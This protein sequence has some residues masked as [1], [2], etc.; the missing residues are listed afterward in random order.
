[1]EGHRRCLQISSHAPLPTV[2]T[3][4]SGQELQEA[5]RMQ[6]LIN[7][8]KCQCHAFKARVL[9]RPEAPSV[10][11]QPARP[12]RAAAAR[13]GVEGVVGL[14]IGKAWRS[15]SRRSNDSSARSLNWKTAERTVCWPPVDS[16]TGP[17]GLQSRR[18]GGAA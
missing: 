14:R 16:R 6:D 9:V 8:L 12:T 4:I 7:L 17:A 15:R 3:W 5:W 18:G 13:L 2:S 11:D 1:L 10:L